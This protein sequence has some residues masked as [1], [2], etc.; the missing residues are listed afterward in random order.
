MLRRNVACKQTRVENRQQVRYT[1]WRLCIGLPFLKS[2]AKTLECKVTRPS[3]V[4]PSVVLT[5]PVIRRSRQRRRMATATEQKR[6]LPTSS[7]ANEQDTQAGREGNVES[8]PQE[9]EK[10]DSNDDASSPSEQTQPQVHSNQEEGPAVPSEEGVASPNDYPSGLR[11]WLAVTALCLGIFLSTL[12][13]TVIATATPYITDEFHSLG[14]VG[15]YA[16]IYPMAIAMSQLTYGKLSARYPIRWIYTAAVFFFLV[17]S[18]VSA[19]APNSSAL[20]A[21]RA[22]AGLGSSGILVGAFSL[23]PFIAPPAK[24]PIFL[25][26][27]GAARGVAATCG[28]LIGGALTERVSW[29]WNF[30]INLPLCVTIYIVFL[31]SVRPPRRQMDGFTSWADL[32]QTLDLIGLTVLAGSVVCLLLTLQWGGIQY[33]WGNARIIALLVLFGALGL[34]FVAIEIK[35]GSKAM[36]PARVFTQR[37]VLCA[38]FFAFCT[39]GAAFVLTYYLPL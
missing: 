23:V 6:T 35:Q 16:S 32:L 19:S 5:I 22:I 18:A 14:D 34:A 4:I 28:P 30:Y 9:T 37:S 29:R 12:D 31:F 2:V 13:S 33:P 24:R 7:M 26:L 25:A 10:E 3:S 27:I 39:A 36:L 21:G 11:F 38:T 1:S 8:R 20:I 15:W 17:G